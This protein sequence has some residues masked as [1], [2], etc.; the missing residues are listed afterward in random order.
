[1]I[2]AAGRGTR[3]GALGR[4]Q[5]KTLIE[6]EGMPLLEHH[7][8]YLERHGV[9]RVVVNASHLASQIEAFADGFAGPPSLE[10]IVEQEALGTAGGVINALTALSDDPLLVLYGDVIVREE[11]GPMA[12]VH[13]HG[14]RVATLAVYHSDQA[15]GK[16]VVE[17]EGEAVTGFREKDP[18][19]ESGWI[20]AGIYIVEPGWLAGFAGRPP[21]DFG[22]DLFPAALASGLGLGAYKLAD[23]VLD[24]GTPAD[25]ASA[26]SDGHSAPAALSL[27]GSYADGDTW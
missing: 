18:E 24:I 19:V 1:M 10:V 27:G 15:E 12:A 13:D 21:L 22:F 7:L 9:S 25:L 20:N 14:D 11:I 4:R 5:A 23:P 17:L 3:L 2:L 16:G 26:E 6:F 8:R